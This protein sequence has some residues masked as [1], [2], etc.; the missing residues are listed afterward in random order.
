MQF[1][2]PQFI[3]VEDKIIGPLTF[4]QFVF[5]AGGGGLAFMA[6]KWI[7][8]GLFI[9][10]PFIVAG[11]AAGIGLAMGSYNERPIT[12][13]IESAFYFLIRGKMFQWNATH[14][15]NPSVEKITSATTPSHDPHNE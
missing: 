4:K 12:E 14:T 2:V 3:E 10:A 5:I 9:S 8:G 11:I 15:L 1:Q 13:A 6:W 7:P